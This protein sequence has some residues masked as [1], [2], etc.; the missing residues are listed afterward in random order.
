MIHLITDSAADFEPRELEQ[1]N[2]TCIPLSV[3]FGDADYQENVNLTKDQFYELLLNSGELPKTSQASPQILLDLFEN[4]RDAGDEAIYFTLSSALSGTYQSACMTRDLAESDRCHVVDSL[5]ATGGQRLIL[6]H[7][8]GLRAEGKTTEEIIAGV[9]DLRSRIV[10]FA[11]IDT[12]E[13][14]YKGGR[15]SQTVYKLGTLANIKPIITVEPD[16]SI[17]IPAK[18][19]GMRKGMDLLCKQ[20]QSRPADPAFPFYVMY[21]NNRSV[22]EALA[23]KLAAVGIPVPDERI[24]QVGA[25]IGSHIGPDACG[26]VYVAAK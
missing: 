23:A 22:A 12:L 18:A 26:L 24:I 6:E 2:I 15:I 14:L 17:G 25:A 4:A 8:A 16:G 19:M 13:Y 10:L 3:R 5:N 20:A 9:E 1:L 7:A 11:C 21:T